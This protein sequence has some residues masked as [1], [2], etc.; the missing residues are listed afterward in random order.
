MR[1]APCAVRR[2]LRAASIFALV[3]CHGGWAYRLTAMC[4]LLAGAA[5]VAAEREE[6]A[7][8]PGSGKR[9][10]A[11]ALAAGVEGLLEPSVKRVS[12][13]GL[14]KVEAN[15]DMDAFEAAKGLL[16]LGDGDR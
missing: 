4:L 16:H 14:D 5:C 12:K 9:T 3:R 7:A 13:G 10:R 1:R 15:G 6:P 2:M 11:A 8:A